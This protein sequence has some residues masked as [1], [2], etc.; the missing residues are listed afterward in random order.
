M[1]GFGFWEAQGDF[2]SGRPGRVWGL[3][4][5]VWGLG[6]GFRVWGLGFGVSGLG[7][8]V[9]GLGLGFRVWGLGRLWVYATTDPVQ[10][11]PSSDCPPRK[12]R[13][14][15]GLADPRNRAAIE[16]EA[17]VCG[18]TSRLRVAAVGAA[19]SKTKRFWSMLYEGSQSRSVKPKQSP[20]PASNPKTRGGAATA[21][22]VTGK[23]STP[24]DTRKSLHKRVEKSG[25]AIASGSRHLSPT[26]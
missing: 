19:I 24:R 2:G 18:V 17:K 5:R 22:C 26:P 13:G 23:L 14:K 15:T 1:P 4:F 21:L 7:F 8:R 9:W 16:H 11:F 25:L 6:F 12:L 10:E 20:V 3:G